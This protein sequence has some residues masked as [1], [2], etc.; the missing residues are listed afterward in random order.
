MYVVVNV[1]V[2]SLYA[3]DALA[4]TS[5]D[6]TTSVYGCDMSAVMTQTAGDIVSQSP[7]S[8]LIHVINK[9]STDLQCPGDLPAK[10]VGI[11]SR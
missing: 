4:M 11:V 2:F 9:K 8:R 7:F 6:S 1:C 3:A 5:R 10:Y